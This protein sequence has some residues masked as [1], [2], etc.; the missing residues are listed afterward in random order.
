LEQ[1]P[2]ESIFKK[3]YGRTLA[4]LYGYFRDYELAEDALQEA[5]TTA[6]VRWPQDGLPEKPGAW[7]TVVAK[8]RGLDV[9]R[10]RQRDRRREEAHQEEQGMWQPDF[11]EAIHREFPDQRLELFF[12]CCHPALAPESQTALTLRSFGRLTTSEIAQAFLV[13]EKTMAQR[14]VRAKRKL[15][16]A[17]IPFAIPSGPDLLP[18]YSGV[19]QTIYLIFNEGY[20]SRSTAH[21]LR[22]DLVQD[23]LFLV[24]A[25]LE[26]VRGIRQQELLAETLGLQALILF[27]LAR[28][29][30]R[31]KEKTH[32]LLEDQDRSLWDR[33]LIAQGQASLEEALDLNSPGPY[34]IQGAI[35]ALHCE[36]PS[37][38]DSDWTQICLLYQR[39]VDLMPSPSAKLALAV[40]HGNRGDLEEAR[41]ILSELAESPIARQLSFALTQA[42]LWEKSGELDRALQIY[43]EL[44]QENTFGPLSLTERKTVE[45]KIKSCRI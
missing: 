37:F 15:S 43:Q 5:L 33:H 32:I 39:L 3:E 42:F 27:A 18:R 1:S 10:K 34:Q 11:T 30:A 20:F 23:A 13:E 9:I 4:F 45:K 44:L 41:H 14:L 12:T 40:A 17:G 26:L 28:E 38:E 7:L 35:S 6:I 25:L 29:P 2:F 31:G 21:P 24:K 36:A 19:L 16:G 22:Q 8:N